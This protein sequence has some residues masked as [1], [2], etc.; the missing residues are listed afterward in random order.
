MSDAVKAKYSKVFNPIPHVDELPTN[1]Y[2]QIK[3]KDA[4]KMFTTCSYSSP[5]KY[6]EAWATLIQQHLY[7]GRIHLS[8]SAH[9]SP[10]FLVPKSDSIELPRWVNYYCQLNANT[11]LDAFP[12]PWIDDI[13]ADCAKGK[14]WSKMDITNSFFQTWLKKEFNIVKKLRESSG[15]GWDSSKNIVTATADIWERYINNL[16]SHKKA[17]IWRTKPFLLYD[18]IRILVEGIVAT[19]EGVFCAGTAP[20]PNMHDLDHGESLSKE[21]KTLDNTE[22]PPVGTGRKRSAAEMTPLASV[23]RMKRQQSDS[24]SVSHSASGRSGTDA[25]FSVAGTISSLAES[26]AEDPSILT[27]PQRHKAAIQLLDENDDLSENEQVQAISIKKKIT[28]TLYI[29]SELLNL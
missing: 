4:S 21:Y 8:N 20:Q 15:F 16:K 18:S 6:K 28:C 9:A 22:S 26:F 10:A 2:F 3:L 11:V 1:V 13:L 29:Q 19:G 24:Q 12:L 25:M 5:H 23:S 7:A 27:S 14:I 17:A